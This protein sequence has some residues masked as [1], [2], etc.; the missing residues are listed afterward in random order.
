MPRPKRQLLVE[1]PLSQEEL[2]NLDEWQW[3]PAYDARYHLYSYPH[4]AH[5]KV[6]A[7]VPGG[8]PSLCCWFHPEVYKSKPADAGPIPAR[9]CSLDMLPDPPKAQ[10][11]AD[12]QTLA[13]LYNYIQ[14][15]NT[16]LKLQLASLQCMINEIL[17]EIRKPTATTIQP[18]KEPEAAMVPPSQ[19]H[20]EK[21]KRATLGE[22]SPTP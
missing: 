16:A 5:Y 11:E 15:E 10:P 3:N 12:P 20:T 13:S 2:Q 4:G 7:T 14:V 8:K 18:A 17:T 21:C 22:L 1:Q 9:G 6:K 19:Q